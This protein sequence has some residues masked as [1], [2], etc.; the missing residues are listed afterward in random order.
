MKYGTVIKR[1]TF[2]GLCYYY[3][4]S[5]FFLVY[6]P[7]KS[8]NNWAPIISKRVKGK[9]CQLLDNNIK[10]EINMRDQ[11][12]RKARN[13]NIEKD[14]S[15]YKLNFVS[16][17]IKRAKKLHYAKMLNSSSKPEIAMLPFLNFSFDFLKELVLM[18][19]LT[20]P[21]PLISKE[22]VKIGRVRKH[23]F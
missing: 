19:I 16:T 11:L 13:T 4:S 18:N 3:S 1:N 5:E 14:C 2:K 7:F 21:V 6:F 20:T 12:L 17:A 10:K 8:L 9:N 22:S 15:N 23:C